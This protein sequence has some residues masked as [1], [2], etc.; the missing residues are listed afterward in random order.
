MANFSN[1]SF[2]ELR[3]EYWGLLSKSNQKIS[4]MEHTK[5]ENPT[6]AYTKVKSN[7][8]KLGQ[9]RFPKLSEFRTSDRNK[10]LTYISLADKYVNSATF[11]F[12]GMEE[13]VNKSFM[14]LA[15]KYGFLTDDKAT[16]KAV[17]DFWKTGVMDKIRELYNSIPSDEIVSLVSGT[18]NGKADKIK[19]VTECMKDWVNSQG[20]YGNTKDDLEDYITFRMGESK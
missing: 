15:D 4:A 5:R 10:L 3:N 2:E 9:E 14:T 17:A 7:L 6:Y 1:M 11:S 16:K 12:K 13:T 20:E 8:E 18:S 19:K